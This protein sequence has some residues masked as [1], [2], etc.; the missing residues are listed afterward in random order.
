MVCKLKRRQLKERKRLPTTSVVSIKGNSTEFSYAEALKMARSKISLDKLEIRS[1]RIRKSITESTLIEIAGPDSATKVDKLASEIQKLLEGE[2][3]VNRPNIR[4]E[5]RMFGIDESI[6]PEEIRDAVAK[7]GNC[8]V[9]EVKMGRVD[10]T[11]TGAGVIW[12]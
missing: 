2:A 10:K 8:K 5:L 7:E 11:C 12:I 6:D 9:E 4:E 3:H 1:P